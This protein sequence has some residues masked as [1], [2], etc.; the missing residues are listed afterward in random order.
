M[1]CNL[2]PVLSIFLMMSERRKVLFK[3]KSDKVVVAMLNFLMVGVYLFELLVILPRIYGK[4]YGSWHKIAHV[5]AG[6]FAVVSVW[7]LQ[8][9]YL[10]SV[11]CHLLFL[12]RM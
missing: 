5:I 4:G 12:L 2:L 1:A 6:N 3:S 11:V 10:C 8:L 7:L 9:L